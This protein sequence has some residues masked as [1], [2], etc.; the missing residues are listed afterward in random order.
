MNKEISLNGH[1]KII[2]MRALRICFII[3]F[4]FPGC[5]SEDIPVVTTAEVT[6]VM[7]TS[8]TCGG[9]VIS[10]G[11][12]D[13][14]SRGIYLGKSGDQIIVDT[15]TVEST[16]IGSFTCELTG[17]DAGTD[18][19]VNAY[20]TNL[21]GTG[22]G[23]TVSFTTEPATLPVVYTYPYL[24]VSQTSA[25]LNGYISSDGESEI[26]EYGFCW[27]T[28]ENP[29]LSDNC[30]IVESNN[31]G[32]FFKTITNLEPNIT[33]FTR[34]F[35]R[36]LV[37]IGYGNSEWFTTCSEDLDTSITGTW[38]NVED[39]DCG[40]Y[41]PSQVTNIKVIT[42][43]STFYEYYNDQLSFSSPFTIEPRSNDF[44][45]IYFSSSEARYPYYD[46]RLLDCNNIQIMNPFIDYATDP[47]DYYKRIE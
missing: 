20:A 10:R 24:P 7:Q 43:D 36:N 47:C 4:L 18:Y 6:A 5:R 31:H 40:L 19:F 16:G 8:A 35:A 23:D 13:V 22:L 42:S 28:S 44:Y 38:L 26:I 27:S 32:K 25:T 9:E 11:D 45:R 41:F 12:A 39:P 46:Y 1:I 33:Y 2:L 14:T 34:S 15:I 17:L 30:V 29:T 37:G 21:Y 3:M